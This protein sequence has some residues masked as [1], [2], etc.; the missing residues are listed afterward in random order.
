MNH[1][2]KIAGIIPQFKY[3]IQKIQPSIHFITKHRVWEGFWNYG[4]VARFLLIVALLAGLKFL[5]VLFNWFS[6][7]HVDDP[8]TAVANMGTLFKDFALEG[9]DFLFMGSMK[10]V[11]LILLEVVVFH[12]CRRTLQILSGKDSKASF[13]EFMRAQIRMIK[14]VIYSYIMEM[15]F[16]VVLKVFFSIFG[17]IDFLQPLAIFGVQCYYLGFAILDNYHEQFGLTIKESTKYAQ[18]YIGVALA[19]GILVHFLLLVPVFGTI[20]TPFLAA[21]LV[22]IVMYELSDLHLLGKDLEMELDELV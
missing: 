10:Y 13:Q 3:T 22:T 11:M 8:I 2:T 15:I 1:Q 5:S 9:Y 20:I 19:V 17:F 6:K 21:V 14:V 16:T 18:N 12:V 7:A 4:W